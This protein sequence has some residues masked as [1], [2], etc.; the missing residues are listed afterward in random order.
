MKNKHLIKM[1][2]EI[3]TL[4]VITIFFSYQIYCM[5]KEK[6]FD[7]TNTGIPVIDVLA[8]KKS[9]ETQKCIRESVLNAI[10]DNN[11]ETTQE[12]IDHILKSVNKN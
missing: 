7:K 10:K 4:I 5:Y 1:V 3:T 11:F 12:E 2:L 9:C 6:Q 8:I